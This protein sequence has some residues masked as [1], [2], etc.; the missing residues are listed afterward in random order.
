M[1]DLPQN[2]PPSVTD[3]YSVDLNTLLATPKGDAKDKIDIEIG[4]SKQPDFKPQFKVMRIAWNK[5]VS[6]YST[7]W[8]GG[9]HSNE[10][11]EKM[12]KSALG[13][14]MSEEQKIKI[15]LALRGRIP[16]NLRTL[17]NSGAKSHW[18]K[19]GITSE[20]E[21]IRK[22]KEYKRWRTAVF[23]RDNFECKK[24][25]KHSRNLH[26]HHIRNYAE[27]IDLRFYVSNGITFC[28]PCHRKFHKVFGS[29]SNTMSQIKK[30]LCQ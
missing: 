12:R 10:A 27:Y 11:K 20:N 26:P 16:K 14:K 19:G 24:C 30:Y 6:G 25:E 2:L 22:S 17:D 9:K 21:R 15:S 29:S 4:D 28:E 5:G 1:T 18:W 8:K 13:R 7:K 23:T 3:K